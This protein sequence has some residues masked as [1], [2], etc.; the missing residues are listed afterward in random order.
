MFLDSLSVWSSSLFSYWIFSHKV[1]LKTLK[2]T[3]RGK[4]W[5]GDDCH[6][7]EKKIPFLFRCEVFTL[8]FSFLPYPSLFLP[9]PDRPPALMSPSDSGEQ[10]ML[11]YPSI[12]I[13]LTVK[14]STL[15]PGNMASPVSWGPADRAGKVAHWEEILSTKKDRKQFFSH[16]PLT[17]LFLPSMSVEPEWVWSCCNSASEEAAWKPCGQGDSPLS[18]SNSTVRNGP[19][20]QESAWDLHS[21]AH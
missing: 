11:T 18:S 5:G 1:N 8:S 2:E 19:L 20:S 21:K 14:G 12:L 15:S 3:S 16:K 9:S 7:E 17:S 6:L 13:F 4:F 10:R